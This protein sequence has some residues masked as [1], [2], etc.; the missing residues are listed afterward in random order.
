MAARLRPYTVWVFAVPALLLGGVY[1]VLGQQAIVSGG[2]ATV[3]YP[4]VLLYN[5]TAEA[6]STAILLVAGTLVALWVPQALGRRPRAGWNGVAV[7]LALAGTTLACWGT[8]P[9]VFTPYLPMGRTT[10][11]GHV[12]QLGVRYGASNGAVA[13]SYVYCECDG[14]GLTCQCHD[15]PAAGEPVQ[16]KAELLADP[17]AGMLAIQVGSQTV[18]RFQ[19]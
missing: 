6:L 14:S 5:Y 2:Q 19:P 13:G 3:F 11:G 15:L 12:Y 9:S 10:L 18:Y 16:A 7:A 17:S 8:L 4:A 1:A